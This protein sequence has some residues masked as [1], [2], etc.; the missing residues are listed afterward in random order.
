MDAEKRFTVGDDIRVTID[1][2]LT[3]ITSDGKLTVQYRSE[4][5]ACETSV[6]LEGT[7]PTVKIDHR[8]CICTRGRS[9]E[10]YD[11]PDRDC[12]EHGETIDDVRGREQRALAELARLREDSDI[13]AALRAAGVD[14][15]D[16]Y[17]LALVDF[18]DDE[19]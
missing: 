3:G 4:L 15:W 1:G 19:D 10:D 11:G 5:G 8:P 17:G 12:P 14:N 13:L 9:P 6:E 18:D 16:G 2:T 7:Q